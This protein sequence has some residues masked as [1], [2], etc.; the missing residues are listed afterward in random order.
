MSES[1]KNTSQREK[2][3]I[4]VLSAVLIVFAYFFFRGASLDRQV[5]IIED[6]LSS[7]DKK[8]D[9][10]IKRAQKPIKLPEYNGKKIETSDIKKLEKTIEAEQTSL[11]GSGHVFVDL[12]NASALP[13]L[14]SDITRTA[15]RNGLLVI[16]KRPHQGDLIQMV[17][18]KMTKQNTLS[19]APS[20]ELKR[21]LYD[22][23]VSGNF[24]AL[25][26][27]LQEIGQLNYSVVLTRLRINTTDRTALSGNRMLDIEMTLAL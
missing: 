6:Q 21:P 20:G 16:S 17:T 4:A 5:L 11:E 8:L 14:Q 13:Q 22:L 26:S 19:K 12:T 15:E 24:Y 25:Q 27:F 3:L 2:V 10:Q 7:I 1:L 18:G 9:R 23:Y